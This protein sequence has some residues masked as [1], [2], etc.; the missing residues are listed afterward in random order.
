MQRIKEGLKHFFSLNGYSSQVFQDCVSR[1]VSK[2][3]QEQPN[4]RPKEDSVEYVFC[5][6]YIGKPSVMYSR[7]IKQIFKQY[8]CINVKTVFTTF[9]VKNYFSL[10]CNTPLA[11]KSKVVYKFNCLRDA[12]ISYIGKTI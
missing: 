8:Y 5:I 12:D 10:K 2:K 7:K 1:F 4:S 3:V 9:K 11:L 6:P